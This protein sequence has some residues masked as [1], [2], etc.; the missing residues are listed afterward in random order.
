MPQRRARTAPPFM[1]ANMS[2]LKTQPESGGEPN[3]VYSLADAS[4]ARHTPSDW[5]TLPTEVRAIAE[6]VWAQRQLG[7]S[8][9]KLE[10]AEYWDRDYICMMMEHGIRVGDPDTPLRPFHVPNAP[11]CEHVATYLA[12]LRE[13]LET[14]LALGRTIPRPASCE[15]SDY[16]HSIFIKDE[17]KLD[18]P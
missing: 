7:I 18:Q 11:E 3:A 6:K 5:S 15:P 17:S 2:V 1:S 14:E 16:V 4:T 12:F 8:L 10:L 9:L 13:S